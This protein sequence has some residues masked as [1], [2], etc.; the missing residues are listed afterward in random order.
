MIWLKALPVIC[1]SVIS[2]ALAWGFCDARHEA[3][4]EGLLRSQAEALSLSH[5]ERQLL[6]DA[7]AIA[8]RKSI[9]RLQD[10][11]NENIG[12]A[13]AV[14]S[15]AKRLLIAANC[16]STA[17]ASSSG[18]DHA[19]TAELDASVRPNYYALKSGINQQRE[20]LMACQ[21]ILSLE[22]K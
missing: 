16:S 9:T 10:L 3:L 15:G 8:D 5:S 11:Q 19:T 6:A 18:V 12:L 7:M 13:A 21:E 22:R 14:S 4:H 2:G 17:V 1:S 20:Q